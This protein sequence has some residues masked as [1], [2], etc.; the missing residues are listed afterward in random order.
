MTPVTPF[1]K[2][3]SIVASKILLFFV[4]LSMSIQALASVPIYSDKNPSLDGGFTIS[5]SSSIWN[6]FHSSANSGYVHV[7]YRPEVGSGDFSMS[8]IQTYTR[9]SSYTFSN[10]EAGEYRLQ[11]RACGT[12]S[13]GR[14]GG[15][16][17]TSTVLVEVREADSN[18]DA[19]SGLPAL[20]FDSGLSGWTNTSAK[21]W[22]IRSNGTPSSYTGPSGAVDGSNYAY[23]ETSSGSAYT[24][25]D[26]ASLTSPSFSLYGAYVSFHYHMYG[27]NI[28]TLELQVVQNG[29]ATTIWQR[30]GQQQSSSTAFWKLATASLAGFSGTAQ[31]RFVGTAAGGYRGDMAIDKI[32]I[33]RNDPPYDVSATA[34]GSDSVQ[35]S[36]NAEAS[37]DCNAFVIYYENLAGNESN[38]VWVSNCNDRERTIPNLGGGRWQFKVSQYF[39]RDFCIPGDDCLNEEWESRRVLAG[40]VDMSVAIEGNGPTPADT[41][42]RRVV[43]VHTDLLGSPAAETDEQG[44]INE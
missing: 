25:G 39:Q 30:T 15:C 43:Y 7:E 40:V 26:K 42:T 36:W 3:T 13:S 10:K 44:E 11:F 22:S 18:T 41:S 28:G 29:V 35:I 9:I 19:S 34:V 4:C 14:S 6:Y 20:S 16:I 12:Y 33:L 23:M 27:A 17:L 38:D 5:W 37:S 21:V 24:A 1:Q 2:L 8:V 32:E 31:L